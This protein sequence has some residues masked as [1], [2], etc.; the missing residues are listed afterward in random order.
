MEEPTG[1]ETPRSSHES[2]GALLDAFRAHPEWDDRRRESQLSR[3][4]QRH[5]PEELRAE[6]RWR[7]RDLSGADGSPVLR[8]LQALATPEL[9]DGLARALIDQP[10]LSPERAWEAL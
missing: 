8:L 2:P 9:L 10:H 7:L 5:P 4:I 1:E 6:L 3:L